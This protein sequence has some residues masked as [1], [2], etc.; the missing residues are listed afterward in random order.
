MMLKDLGKISKDDYSNIEKLNELR[1][2]DDELKDS[3]SEANGLRNRLVYEYN[4]L[5]N[6]V[7]LT[8]KNSLLGPLSKFIDV[9]KKWIRKFP[10]TK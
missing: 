2:L 9:V 1:I 10:D 4:E 6:L 8:S 7:A 5:N 3:L